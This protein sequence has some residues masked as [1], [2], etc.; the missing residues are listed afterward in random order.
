MIP[1]VSEAFKAI[2]SIADVVT[3]GADKFANTGFVKILPTESII[4]TNSPFIGGSAS[5]RLSP[6]KNLTKAVSKGMLSK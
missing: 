4:G 2:P 3:K 1:K 6:S 5:C